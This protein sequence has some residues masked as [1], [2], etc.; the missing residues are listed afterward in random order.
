MTV[1][2]YEFE[3]NI[4]RDSEYAILRHNYKGIICSFPCFPADW[5]DEQ[6]YFALQFA[7]KVYSEGVEYGSKMKA[8]EIRKTLGL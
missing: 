3:C 1:Y 6:I 7:N 2:A 8:D 5:S 4:E